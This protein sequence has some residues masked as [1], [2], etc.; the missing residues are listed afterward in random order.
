MLLDTFD[1]RI[2]E[3][4]IVKDGDECMAELKFANL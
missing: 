3:I 1:D 2:E 4:A